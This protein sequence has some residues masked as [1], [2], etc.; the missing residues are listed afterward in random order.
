MDINALTIL[1]IID[2]IPC[3]LPTII[4]PSCLPVKDAI[5]PTKVNEEKTAFIMLALYIISSMV[6]SDLGLSTPIIWGFIKKTADTIYP[7][8]AEIIKRIPTVV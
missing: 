7:I 8:S 1:N 4:I 3:M 2:K 6:I 5:P